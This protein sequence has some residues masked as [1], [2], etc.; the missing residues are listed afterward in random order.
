MQSTCYLV[1]EGDIALNISSESGVQ[2][3]VQI[4]RNG[5]PAWRRGETIEGA[6][7]LGECVEKLLC[8]LAPSWSYFTDL[9]K[10]SP[11]GLMCVIEASGNE[12]TPSLHLTSS[13]ISRLHELGASLDVD[14]YVFEADPSTLD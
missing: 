1:Y 11:P 2:G 3:A 9:G 5:I 8:A 13:A 6:G 4:H 10:T 7:P 12:G 14:I